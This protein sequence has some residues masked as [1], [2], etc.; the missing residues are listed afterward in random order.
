MSHDLA[1]LWPLFSLRVT[2]PRLELAVPDNRDLLALTHA[3]ADIQPPGKPRYQ[4]A[5]LYK[6]SPER[7]RHLLQRH[8]RALAHWQPTSWK[9]HLAIRVDGA[10]IGMQDIWAT[11]FAVVRSVE[12]GSWITRQ[13]QGKGYGTEARAAVLKLAFAHLHAVEAHTS[14]IEGNAASEK[15]S[16]K[17]GYV[18]N[19]QHA[20]RRDDARIVEHRMLLEAVHWQPNRLP[21][22]SVHGVSAC[23]E[24]F[25]AT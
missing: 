19:G 6:P 8:W 21:G 7:E 18:H 2:T 23:L 5:Y 12:T 13:H 22:V 25:G 1:D 24:L 15:V 3:S 9:L 11:D 20:Y 17:L 10:A 4:Q 16:K 14:F